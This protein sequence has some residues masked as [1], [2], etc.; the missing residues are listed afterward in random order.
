MAIIPLTHLLAIPLYRLEYSFSRFALSSAAARAS[1]R[2]RRAVRSCAS[3][4]AAFDSRGIVLGVVGGFIVFGIVLEVGDFEGGGDVVFVGLV[5][6]VLAHTL[7]HF[8]IV[9]VLFIM[10]R[11]ISMDLCAQLTD[12]DA[13]KKT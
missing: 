13:V 4:A 5:A 9:V 7:I 12:V 6:Y 8:R 3:L 10:S 1:I 11:L 2:R